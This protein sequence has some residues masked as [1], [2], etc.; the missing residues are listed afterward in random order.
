MDEFKKGGYDKVNSMRSSLNQSMMSD[1]YEEN[2][3][4]SSDAPIYKK[5]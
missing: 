4:G 3:K 1:Q 2:E 5:E